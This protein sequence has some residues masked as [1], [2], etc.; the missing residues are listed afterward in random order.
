MNEWDNS[1]TFGVAKKEVDALRKD[2]DKL[3]EQ[4]AIAIARDNFKNRKLVELFNKPETQYSGGVVG[5]SVQ[6]FND[7][8]KT[9]NG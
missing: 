5:K 1:L 9:I 8:V 6:S 3:T 7:V 2:N 4:Q